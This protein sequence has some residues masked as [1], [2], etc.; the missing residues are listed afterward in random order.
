MKNEEKFIIFVKGIKSLFQILNNLHTTVEL[1]DQINDTPGIFKDNYDC[2]AQFA[3][4]ME[5][6]LQ[7]LKQGVKSMNKILSLL[8]TEYKYLL[9]YA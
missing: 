3:M 7:E 2:I 6:Y 4:D 9:L 8:D 5:V 1:V